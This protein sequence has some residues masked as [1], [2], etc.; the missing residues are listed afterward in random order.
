MSSGASCS[1]GRSEEGLG[2]VL[3][4]RGG[5]GSGLEEVSD[6]CLLPTR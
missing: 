2:E 6:A 3:G 5:Y 4:G 1:A